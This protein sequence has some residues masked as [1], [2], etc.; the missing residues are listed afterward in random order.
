MSKKKI[1]I[2]ILVA[3][4]VMLS[5]IYVIIRIINQP[6]TTGVN[7]SAV[8][9]DSEVY[10]DGKRVGSGIN[11]TKPGTHII[12]VRHNNFETKTTQ[13]KSIDNQIILVPIALSANTDAG[14]TWEKN[15]QNAYLALQGIGDKQ[16]DNSANALEKAYPI[17]KKLPLDNSPLFRIDYGVSI[18]YPND[19]TRTALYI[20]SDNPTDKFSAIKNIYDLGFDPSDYEIIF[21]GI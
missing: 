21:K 17:V 14:K 3:A 6:I 12:E 9:S 1:L 8:P 2:I 18:K 19:P 15:N 4:F 7:I 16:Y 10:I 20:S 5:G 11:T 13:I